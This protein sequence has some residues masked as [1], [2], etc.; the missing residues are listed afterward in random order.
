MNQGPLNI[1]LIEDNPGD[2]RLISELLKDGRKGFYQLA[3]VDRIS[4]GVDHLKQNNMDIVLLDLN[5]PDST[6]MDGLSTVKSI[7]REVPIIVL[8]GLDDEAVA[9]TA[10]Q[11]GAQDYLVKGQ[12][13]GLLLWRS[14]RYAIERK[15]QEQKMAYMA[16]HDSLTGLP[17]RFLLNDRL[18][19]A[20]TQAERKNE[21]LAVMM[22]DLDHFKD[23]NDSL[24]HNTGDELLKSVGQRLKSTLRGYDTVARLGGDEFILLLTEI[25]DFAGAAEIASRIV[26]LFQQPFILDRYSLSITTSIGIAVYPDHS[27]EIESLLRYADIAMYMAKGNGRCCYAV[28]GEDCKLAASQTESHITGE[29]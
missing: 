1:M 2:A 9:V 12:V 21:K 26:T 4:K 3:H 24:G 17:N 19:M 14:I 10:V 13:D 8:T 28:F 11:Y 5:L 7:A 6:G 27:P 15:Q 22:L 16:T 29:T 20:I 25:S 18:A 23:V